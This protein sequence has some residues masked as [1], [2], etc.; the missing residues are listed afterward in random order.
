LGLPGEGFTSVNLEILIVTVT[1]VLGAFWALIYLRRRS[2]V[3]PNISHSGF[4]SL[5][6]LRVAV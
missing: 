3:A 4:N 6:V 1:G 5:E 2:A